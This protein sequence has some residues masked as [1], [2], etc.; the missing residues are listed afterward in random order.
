MAT[1]ATDSLE[2]M[3]GNLG[4]DI[5]LALLRDN[6][7]FV[8]DQRGRSLYD[9]WYRD[10]NG[11]MHYADAKVRSLDPAAY[12][13][14]YSFSFSEEKLCRYEALAAEKDWAFELWVVDAY[15]GKVYVGNLEHLRQ[16]RQISG[17]TFPF[18]EP[19]RFGE[20]KK[21]FHP[22][23]FNAVFKI[24]P[25]NQH[26]QIL[27]YL[28]GLSEVAAVGDEQ[29]NQDSL[30]KPVDLLTAPNGINIDILAVDGTSFFFVKAARIYSAFTGKDSGISLNHPLIRAANAMGVKWYRFETQR[31][32]GGD[33]HGSKGYYFA[34]DDVSKVLGQYL[35]HNHKSKGKKQLGYNDSARELR[36]WFQDNV[37]P[38]YGAVTARN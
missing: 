23:Q 1:E 14:R 2:K 31:L 22:D 21:Y 8:K 30:A 9:F 24:N 16:S 35:E 36:K 6:F 5:V 13:K 15:G 34:V 7:P 27:R 26:L 28:Y 20:E 4:E 32:S 25:D 19:N 38:L 11:L 10:E 17:V 18:T 37:L 3:K 29:V 33:S 12:G